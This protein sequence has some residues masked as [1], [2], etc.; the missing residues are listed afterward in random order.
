ME[1]TANQLVISYSDPDI[2]MHL[3]SLSSKGNIL[4]PYFNQN[5]ELFIKLNS[6]VTIPSIPIHHNV[7]QAVPGREYRNKL[8]SVVEC[9]SDA[10]PDYFAG[11]QYYFDPAEVLHP[12]FFQVYKLKE[13]SYLYLLRLDLSFRTY[14]SELKDKGSNDKTPEYLTNAVFFEADIIP[15]E[16]VYTN[17]NNFTGFQIDQLVSQNWIGETGR[18]YMVQGIWIDHELTKFFT[19][20]FVGTSQKIYPYYP[21]SCK[22]RTLCHSIVKPDLNGR[23]EGIPLIHQALTTVRPWMDFIQKLLKTKRFN[24]GMKEFLSLKS[25]VPSYWD[26]QWR[27]YSVKSY[28]NSADMKEFSLA[29]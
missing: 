27:S 14:Y 7:N 25:S 23:K 29:I 20:L 18:G 6:P 10:I 22:Y 24:P 21:F 8:L 2:N 9:V 12:C 11:L 26:S 1:K 3:K 16:D 17:D 13:K 4:P 15:L 5:E 19:K 28:L